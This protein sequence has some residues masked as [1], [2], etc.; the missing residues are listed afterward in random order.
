MKAPAEHMGTA[1]IPGPVASCQE[2]RLSVDVIVD[3]PGTPASNSSAC[4]CLLT[5]SGFADLYPGLDLALVGHKRKVQFPSGN[6]EKRPQTSFF[7]SRAPCASGTRT[8][9]SEHLF[10]SLPGHKPKPPA[11]LLPLCHPQ[12]NLSLPD[13]LPWQPTDRPSELWAAQPPWPRGGYSPG[14]EGCECVAP[15]HVS[16]K[17]DQL[18]SCPSGPG[19]LSAHL[20]RGGPVESPATSPPDPLP[21]SRGA[22]CSR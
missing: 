1:E 5:S 4:L 11:S 8:T 13:P 21:S 20:H 6:A 18:P 17:A 2:L 10:L 12:T 3:S 16:Q 19:Q 15:S 14:S 9:D 7:V 22:S